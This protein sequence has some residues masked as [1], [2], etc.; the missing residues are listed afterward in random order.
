MGGD[1]GGGGLQGGGR[2]NETDSHVTLVSGGPHTM[3]VKYMP[4]IKAKNTTMELLDKLLRN[5]SFTCSDN[6]HGVRHGARQQ[7]E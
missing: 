3:E 4:M 5:R 1:W 2:L 7:Q 6:G